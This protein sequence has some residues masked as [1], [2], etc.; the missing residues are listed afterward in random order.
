[1][2]NSTIKFMCNLHFSRK[3]NSLSGTVHTKLNY[4]FLMF[5]KVKG[6]MLDEKEELYK[7]LR[8]QSHVPIYVVFNSVEDLLEHAAI[9]PQLFPNLQNKKILKFIQQKT[10]FHGQYRKELL[11]CARKYDVESKKPIYI[12]LR[13]KC[14]RL[15]DFFSTTPVTIDLTLFTQQLTVRSKLSECPLEKTIS[16]LK[17]FNRLLIPLPRLLLPKNFFSSNFRE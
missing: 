3:S 14:A 13:Q 15:Q 17:A 6:N 2:N 9:A 5:G 16:P 4:L 1:M 8:H 7:C 11:T 12:V 10:S